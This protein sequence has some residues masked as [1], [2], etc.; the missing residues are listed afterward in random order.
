MRKTF[1]AGAAAL[2]MTPGLA[3]AALEQDDF[4][5][6]TT[7][8]LL[9]VCSAPSNSP[10][11]VRAINFCLGYLEGAAHYHD[12]VSVGKDMGRV[13]CPPP[14][15]TR[16]DLRGIFVSWAKE[17]Q[18]NKNVMNSRALVGLISAAVD[19]WPCKAK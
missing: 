7:A 4:D 3:G 9:D 5:L 12:H 14:G 17:N 16:A 19:K 1:L 13:V 10:M 11:A 15:A 2:A 6:N 8:Q 18:S